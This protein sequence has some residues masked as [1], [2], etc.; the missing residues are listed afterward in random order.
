MHNYKPR[1]VETLFETYI[2]FKTWMPMQEILN[3][4]KIN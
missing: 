1:H 4:G 3:Q 2:H